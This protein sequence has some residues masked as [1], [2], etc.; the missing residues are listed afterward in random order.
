[1]ITATEGEKKLIYLKEKREWSKNLTT[2]LA[3]GKLN[4]LL[5][6]VASIQEHLP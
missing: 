5:R 4:H 1:M 2:K 6:L 3:H